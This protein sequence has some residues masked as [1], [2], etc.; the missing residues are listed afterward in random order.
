MRC[1]YLGHEEG[2]HGDPY[3][4]WEIPFMGLERA[5]LLGSADIQSDSTSLLRRRVV[6]HREQRLVG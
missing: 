4:D 6:Q 3:S 1:R 2:P 5:S